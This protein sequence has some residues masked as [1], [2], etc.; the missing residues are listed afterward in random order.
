[1]VPDFVRERVEL[2]SMT[3]LELGGAAR[4]FVDAT[5]DATLIAALRWA[6]GAGVR[7]WVL[8]GGS[9][10]IVAD[11]GFDGLVVRVRTEGERREAL[12][13]G[14]VR[15]SVAAG[16]RWDDFVCRAV[17]GGLAGVEC[18][19]GIP[20]SVGATPI[21]NVGA[22][23][24]DVRETI[25]SVRVW[26]PSRDALR[27]VSAD[28]CRFAYRDSAFK[29]RSSDLNSCV[30]LEVR[31][32]L[33][34]SGAPSVRYAELQRALEGVSAPTLAQVREAV[35]R[36]RASKSMVWSADD[37]NRRSAGSFFKNPIVSRAVAD[38]VRARAGGA[39][40]PSWD[41]PDGRVKLAAG[42]LIERAGVTR[43]E[44]HGS[45]GISTAHALALVHHGGGSARELL[46]LAE[47]IVERVRAQWG[48]ELER[49]PVVLA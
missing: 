39:S 9:N 8:G 29:D 47:R 15:V 19:S 28:E 27:E 16:E 42:W 34:A 11:E 31:F 21:Q 49:E 13:D 25:E 10:T 48:V 32:V 22:Y 43:G 24:Q 18:L 14:R 7:A 4:Y 30:V 5:D 45:V 12:G 40:V 44:R 33:R 2:A 3:T 23:G 38:G 35:L 41:E 37:A 20:G 26:D 6:R 1:M 36:A 17:E 46:A